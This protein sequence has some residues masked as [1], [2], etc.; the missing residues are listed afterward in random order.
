M[1]KVVD[2]MYTE[3]GRPCCAGTWLAAPPDSLFCLVNWI[4]GK[5]Y[6]GDSL[7]LP[8]PLD[9]KPELVTKLRTT[10]QKVSALYWLEFWHQALDRAIVINTNNRKPIQDLKRVESEYA[11]MIATIKEGLKQSSLKSA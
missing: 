10:D 7:Q 2:C 1:D 6:T 4:L 5:R 8:V 11:G 9:L 3:R